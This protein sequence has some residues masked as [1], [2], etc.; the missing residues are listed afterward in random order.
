MSAFLY[1]GGY[2]VYLWPAYLLTFAVL[3][4]NIV[5]ARRALH[6]AKL[7]AR[8]RTGIDREARP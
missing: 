7:E 5:S 6:D 4:W 2:A 3:A 8:R 1:M